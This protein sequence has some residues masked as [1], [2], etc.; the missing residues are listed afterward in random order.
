[1]HRGDLM[2][3]W[4]IG[5]TVDWGDGFMDAQNWGHG[6]NEEDDQNR[7]CR[8]DNDY[9]R[10]APLDFNIVRGNCVR[11]YRE[12]YEKYMELARNAED[13]DEAVAYYKK[14]IDYG[15]GYLDAMKRNCLT[16]NSFPSNKKDLLPAYDF[17]K[18]TQMHI[19]YRQ[20]PRGFFQK[21]HPQED[22][23]VEIFKKTGNK[24]MR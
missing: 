2:D 19:R 10:S 12:P 22:D 6:Y 17:A 15:I 7:N 11:Q 14:A 13:D 24:I 4:H 21:S 9:R 5:D 1:M 18:C 8:Y 20:K 16:D 3:E 23:L